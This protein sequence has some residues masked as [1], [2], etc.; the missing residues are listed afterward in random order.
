MSSLINKFKHVPVMLEQVLSSLQIKPNGIYVDATVGGAGHSIEIAKKLKTGKLFC[1]DRDPDA[2]KVASK[3]LQNFKCALVVEGS[4]S[5][6]QQKLNEL[7]VKLVDGFLFDLG[8]SSFQL[9]EPSRGFSYK[10]AGPIDM[11]MS[12]KGA[13]ALEAVNNLS[14]EQ[15]TE[16]I[17]KFGEERF[18]KAISKKIVFTR[19]KSPLLTTTQL[20]EVVKS[21]IPAKFKRKKNPC[22][23]TFQALRMFINNEL[24]ELAIG[25][26]SSFKLLK[27]GGR[28]VFISFHSLEDKL[29]KQK[30]IELSTGCTCP[31]KTPICI[32]N[33]KPKAK[34]LNRKPIVASIEEQLANPRCKSAKLRALE[35]L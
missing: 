2:L 27:P 20:A 18:A 1:F 25:L 23:K 5:T 22:K 7:N 8:V 21:A 19:E 9:D 32:C 17:L 31:P 11:R 26:N 15:L 29:V 14:V 24:E 6:L 30:F 13:S 4:F 34:I 10:S 16:I 12:K 35:K 33:N 28:V 3:R